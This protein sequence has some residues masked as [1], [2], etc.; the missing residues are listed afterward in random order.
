VLDRRLASGAS[1][2]LSGV[3]APGASARGRADFSTAAAAIIAGIS[4]F[5]VTGSAVYVTTTG[6]LG[7]LASS[8]RFKTA[9]APM[10]SNSAKL[11]QLRPVTF[12]LK[13]DPKGA[14]QYGLVSLF[15]DDLIGLKEINTFMQA[16]QSS[17]GDAPKA[18]DPPQTI[19]GA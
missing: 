11:E 6:R 15:P 7:V 16:F 5:T 10:G 3:C 18:G 8:E 2:A 14:L 17:A 1:R 9:I 13:T 4:T 12:H 19:A